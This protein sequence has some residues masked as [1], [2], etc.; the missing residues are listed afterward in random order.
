MVHQYFIKLLVLIC[1]FSSHV[2]AQSTPD[3][4]KC[5]NRVG[6]EWN[7]GRAPAACDSQS[8]GDDRVVLQDYSPLIFNDLVNITSER[9]RYMNELNAVI[10]A[11]AVYYLK[12]RKPQASVGELD[13]WTLGILTTASQESYWSHYRMA[14]DKRLKM[15]RGDFGH[16]HGIMQVDDRAHFNAIEKG[17][18]WNLAAHI[19]Y[20]MDIYYAAWSR[21]PTQKCVRGETDYLARIRSAWSAYNG[22]PSRICR[23]QNPNDKWAKNDKNFYN[24]ITNKRW[25]AFVKDQNK[26]PSVNIAC[27]MEKGTNCTGSVQPPKDQPFEFLPNQLYLVQNQKAC[28]MT[29]NGLQCMEDQKDRACL[30]ALSSVNTEKSVQLDEKIFNQTTAKIWNRHEL[31]KIFEPNLFGTG[32]NIQ[33]QKNI[34]LRSS[35]GAGVVGTLPAKT[36]VAVLD[37]ELR[38]SNT[39]DRYYKVQYQNKTGFIFAGNTGDQ[40]DWVIR[41]LAPTPPLSS[42]AQ[43]NQKIKIVIASGIN[44][45]VSPTGKVITAIPEGAVLTVE[46]V[47][48]EGVDNNI[49]YQVRYQGKV[50]TVYSGKLKPLDTVKSWTAVIK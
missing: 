39:K 41:Y 12:K 38:N 33:V 6:G 37:F 44:L 2:F 26:T 48:T 45:R 15:M 11:A 21:T 25:Q 30:T 3:Y 50:G 22:G 34:N 16:G 43:V 20:A 32:E 14:S 13:A 28:V 18:G 23:W 7:Y 17:I 29:E 47:I 49:Y 36:V 40:E 35:V 24:Q 8:F 46:K 4:Y 5:N 10:K 42:V 27:L 9:S 1:F 31:C 19:T